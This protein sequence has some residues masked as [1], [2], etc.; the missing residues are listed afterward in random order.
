MI[1]P[2][3]GIFPTIHDSVFIANDASIIGDVTIGAQSSTWF[4]TVI[5]GD[6]APVNIGERTSIQDL[7]V[8]HQSPGMPLTIES[9]VTVGHQ[10]TLHSTT[11]QKHA[12]IGMGSILLDGS[13]IG[14]Y[15]FIGAGSLVP[16]NKKIPP[17]TLALGRPAKIVRELTESDYAEMQRICQSYVEKG[18]IY[19]QQNR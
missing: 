18:V 10:T 15:A 12:L 11:I 14:E 19:K 5:R 16:P 7:S 17:F 13:E 3:K 4:K 6:V 2:Y 8:L 9:D 1:H